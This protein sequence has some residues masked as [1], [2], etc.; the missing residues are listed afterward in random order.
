MGNKKQRDHAAN[1]EI[2]NEC[3]VCL[4]L[5]PV[6]R[7]GNYN[8][9]ELSEQRFCPSGCKLIIHRECADQLW[10]E[11]Y[12]SCPICR[13]PLQNKQSVTAARKAQ[14]PVFRRFLR[15]ARSSRRVYPVDASTRYVRLESRYLNM[16]LIE[17]GIL[18]QRV[19]DNRNTIR[20]RF[21]QTKTYAR[22]LFGLTFR[23]TVKR[24]ITEWMTL[25]ISLAR[26]GSFDGNATFT[27]MYFKE[28]VPAVQR[29]YNARN[30]T[31]ARRCLLGCC[32]V[33]ACCACAL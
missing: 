27:S 11:G 16:S 14:S 24:K 20:Y 15:H 19:H 1:R 18:Y 5:A 21:M 13:H 4:E 3:I 25:K 10:R 26:A 2:D 22:S 6:D 23:N 9:S 31:R 17:I 12:R 7:R 32:V 29:L 30:R 28:R 33:L 8:G